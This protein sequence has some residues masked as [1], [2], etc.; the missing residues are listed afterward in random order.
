MF[1][2][3]EFTV[4]AGH[5]ST[6]VLVCPIIN[7]ELEKE[8]LCGMPEELST[9]KFVL[10]TRSVELETG[11][12]ISFTCFDMIIKNP[13]SYINSDFIFNGK[14]FTNSELDPFPAEIFWDHEVIHDE[15]LR[16]IRTRIIKDQSIL[17]DMKL[18][19]TTSSSYNYEYINGIVGILFIENLVERFKTDRVPFPFC[20]ADQKTGIVNYRNNYKHA[21]Y[22][23]MPNL[24]DVVISEKLGFELGL[25]TGLKKE[26]FKQDSC[27]AALLQEGTGG[28]QGD[29]GMVPVG[30]YEFLIDQKT[31]EISDESSAK[32]LPH[33]FTL[34][35]NV[36]DLTKYDKFY[37]FIDRII[38][39]FYSKTSY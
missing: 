24:D 13:N 30:R 32:N 5:Y 17:F 1:T 26:D 35:E 20:Q 31:D 9:S 33:P 12:K 19:P 38:D 25:Q 29:L 7:K 4:P 37:N 27:L 16:Y 39:Y 18:P 34:L 23:Q 11:L 36:E 2:S 21:F 10:F 3:E 22:L 15:N 8:L 28:S 14:C 6:R